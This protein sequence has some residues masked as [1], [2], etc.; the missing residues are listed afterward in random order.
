MSLPAFATIDDLGARL[1][2][3]IPTGDE[4]RAQ[5]AL[6]DASA[7]IRSI[8][9]KTWTTDGALDDDV[10]DIIL[11][12]AVSAAR[13]SFVNPSGVTQEGETA[14]PFNRNVSYANASSDVYLTKAEKSQ[15]LDAAADAGDGGGAF[16][17]DTAPC[18]SD[19]HSLLCTLRFGGAYCSC[20]VDIAGY[21]LYEL[22]A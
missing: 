3:G 16:S 22:D 6:D 4:A 5:A 12:I 8:A 15:V 21:P 14:G 19:N 11:T 20:G 17:I 18:I 13:R 10:P 1:P 2:G 7:L 9:G